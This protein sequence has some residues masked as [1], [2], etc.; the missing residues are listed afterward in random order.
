MRR[1]ANPL[2][3]LCDSLAAHNLLLSLQWARAAS[4]DTASDE[5]KHDDAWLGIISDCYGCRAFSEQRYRGRWF[6]WHG[7]GCGSAVF[8]GRRRRSGWYHAMLTSS[9]AHARRDHLHATGAD[10][11]AV[12]TAAVDATDEA[13]V[14]AFAAG[15]ASQ[16]TMPWSSR[17][18]AGRRTDPSPSLTS[19]T[20]E[21]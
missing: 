3:Y 7:Q 12:E 2:D 10:G 11:A 17:R 13:S 15:L 5:K 9:S 19:R 18:R 8:E 6:I 14:A 1:L 21:E 16:R 4:K 20:L